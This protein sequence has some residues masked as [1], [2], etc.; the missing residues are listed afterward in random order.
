MGFVGKRNR[1]EYGNGSAELDVVCACDPVLGRL[2]L[3]DGHDFETG[4]G[5]TVSSRPAWDSKDPIS[6][7]K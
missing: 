1:K 7:R 5:Y 4:L 2:R 6:K 3:E